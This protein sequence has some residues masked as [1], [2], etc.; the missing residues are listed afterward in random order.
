M[1]GLRWAGKVP[2]LLQA[3]FLRFPPPPPPHT[4]VPVPYHTPV[5]PLP[6]THLC[7]PSPPH[8]CVLPLPS[9]TCVP[10]HHTPVFPLLTTR[11]CFF[12]PTTHLWSPSPPHTC[13][14]LFYHTPVFLLPHHTAVF[15]LPTIHLYLWHLVLHACPLRFCFVPQL[16]EPSLVYFLLCSW[17]QDFEPVEGDHFYYY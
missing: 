6:T 17:Y 8:T 14:S 4:C 5:F 9:H 12:S 7:S 1:T 10:H 13:V 15:P 2:E 16:Q 3:W 11:L